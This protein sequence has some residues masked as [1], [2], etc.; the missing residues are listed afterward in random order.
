MTLWRRG[1]VNIFIIK[2][3]F[4]GEKTYG[5]IDEVMETLYCTLFVKTFLC[6]KV[7]EVISCLKF[8]RTQISKLRVNIKLAQ[9]PLYPIAYHSS[10]SSASSYTSIP[11]VYLSLTRE[12]NLYNFGVSSPY[13]V[14][15][16]VLRTP[17]ALKNSSAFWWRSNSFFRGG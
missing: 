14:Q 13:G 6:P 8:L 16:S 1:E 3:F 10:I 2:D 4:S 12:F 7:V 17:L 9:V 5:S 15:Y 11:K